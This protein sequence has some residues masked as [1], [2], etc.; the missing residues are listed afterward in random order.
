M[1]PHLDY[2][3]IIYHNQRSDLMKLI[4]QV[5]YKSALIVSGCW[6]GTS[7]ERLYEELGWES[8]C[9][10]WAR[11]LTTFYKI[12]N[13]LA[14]S[15]LSDHIAEHVETNISLRHRNARAPF[16]R[17]ERYTNSFSPIV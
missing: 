2:G 7:R 5:Q 1:R 4:E 6:Q 11:R 16:S 13:G 14:P 10:R 9:E 15:Y 17:T 8:L 3:D 12:K